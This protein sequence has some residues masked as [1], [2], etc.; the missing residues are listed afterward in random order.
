MHINWGAKVAILYLSFVALIITLVVS[1]THQKFDLVSND[2]YKQEIEYQH[3]IDASKNQ[4][5]LS[6]PI[7]LLK[8]DDNITINF[9]PDFKDANITGTIQFYSPVDASLDRKFDIATANNSMAI[10]SKELHKT[11]YKVKISWLANGK[12]YYQE[13][14]LNLN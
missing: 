6:A 4:A 1:S 12:N 7:S 8:T 13:T 14:E 9:P 11:N 2:Y 5:A 10:N 3:V